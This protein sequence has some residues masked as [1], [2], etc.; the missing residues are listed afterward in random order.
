MRVI[1]P[2]IFMVWLFITFVSV[3]FT[4]MVFWSKSPGAPIPKSRWLS[5]SGMVPSVAL[6]STRL[7]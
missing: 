4:P 3:F 5:P 6:E 2:P 7:M 1:S